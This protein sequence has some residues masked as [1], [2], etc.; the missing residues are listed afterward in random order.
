MSQHRYAG[1]EERRGDMRSEQ[2]PV[3]LIVGMRDQRHARGNQLGT[4]RLDC[5]V[6]D[7]RLLAPGPRHG[8]EV[9]PMV[10]SRLLAVFELGLGHRRLEVDVPQRGRLELVGEPPSR[11]P[12]EQHLRHA[13][14]VLADGGVGH[15]PVHR[16][17]QI[18]P[19]VLEGLLVLD[20]EPGA[21]LDEVRP[22]YGDRVFV[23]LVGRRER[24]VV[25]QRRIATDAE[26]V[27]DPPL[28]GQPVVVPPHR[29]EHFLPAHALEARDDV[30]VG[31]GKDVS[32]VQRPAHGRRGRVDCIH[33]RSRTGSIEA[34]RAFSLP[35]GGPLLFQ[36]FEC[37]LVRNGHPVMVARSSHGDV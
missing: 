14:R 37:G 5:N 25:W 2:R 28:G 26:V 27:L 36:S 23:R 11:Q 29:V 35:A 33:L 34:V 16:E 22:R 9:D 15:R 18:S 1:A 13:L 32:N 31:V 10:G 3:P 12:Y 30:G 21:Q 6:I 8:L 17:A 7:S 20:G 24:R 4:R 19:Q